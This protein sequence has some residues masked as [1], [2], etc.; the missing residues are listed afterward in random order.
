MTIFQ[1]VG[2]KD[3]PYSKIRYIQICISKDQCSNLPNMVIGNKISRLAT[4]ALGLVPT[5]AGEKDIAL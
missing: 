1:P 2:K 3:K 4:H 5:Q